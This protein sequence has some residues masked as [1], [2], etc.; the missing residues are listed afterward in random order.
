MPVRG[1]AHAAGAV[2]AFFVGL[3]VLGMS[4]PPADE[5]PDSL[6]GA[7]HTF[8]VGVLVSQ[9]GLPEHHDPDW[10]ARAEPGDVLFVSRG[11]VAWGSWSHVAVVV[12][13]PAD[14][15]WAE[16][17]TLAVLDASIHDGMYFSPVDTYAGWPRVVVRRA[18]ADP[19]VRRRIAQAALAHR[20]RMFAGVARSGSPYSN[21]TTSAIE[22][23]AS[24]GLDAGLS[25]WRTPDELFRSEVWLD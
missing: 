7:F 15:I 9:E 25:G 12:R 22:A 11:H 8:F 2:G 23:L 10:R 17:G 19:E 16:P 21:C 24:V 20:H 4:V 3:F 1:L 6:V 14:A 13:A 18:S 5:F